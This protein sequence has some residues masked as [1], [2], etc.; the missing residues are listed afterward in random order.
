M[1]F[2]YKS[3]K[4]EQK[5]NDKREGIGKTNP[6]LKKIFNLTQNADQSFFFL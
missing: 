4:L 1:I 5:T 2:E 6:T 3:D